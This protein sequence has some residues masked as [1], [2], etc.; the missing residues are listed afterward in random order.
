MD[1]VSLSLAATAG[2]GALS[3]FSSIMSGNA[4]AAQANYQAGV[5]QVNATIAKQNAD[6]ATQAGEVE[7]QQ[8]GMKTRAQVGQTIATQGAGGLALGSG[9]QAS[10]VQSER[11]VGA[12]DVSIIRSNAAKRAYGYQVEAM[13]DTSQAE[14]FKMTAT[15]AKTAGIIGAFSSILGTAGSVSSKW[16]QGNAAGLFGSKAGG[17]PDATAFVS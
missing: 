14:L 2:G 4:K 1:P 8:G 5:A 11:E 9:S 10:V 17:A 6:Y 16:M 3:A 15:D 13:Q 12:E 7:A